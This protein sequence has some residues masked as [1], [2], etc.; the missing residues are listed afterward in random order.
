VREREGRG[1]KGERE[2]REGRDG[3]EGEV[4]EVEEGRIE[5]EGGTVS[6]TNVAKC[7]HFNT[8]IMTKKCLRRLIDIMY[9]NNMR[10][11]YTYIIHNHHCT[12]DHPLHT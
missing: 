2:G 7:I 3:R 5:K 4:G 11:L 10:K 9:S 12:H 8:T 6:V 1:G